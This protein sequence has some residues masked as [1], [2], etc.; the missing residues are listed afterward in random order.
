MLAAFVLAWMTIPVPLGSLVDAGGYRVHLYC[1][2]AGSPTVLIA[3]GAFSFDWAL[4]QPEVANFTRVCAYD[5]SGTAWSDSPPQPHPLCTDR[6]QELH[7]VLQKAGISPP[8]VLVG[9]SIGGLIARLYALAYL[10]EIAGMVIVNHAFLDVA[11]DVPPPP[12]VTSDSPPVLISSTPITFGLEDDKNFSRLPEHIR[13]LHAWALSRHPLRPANPTSRT[14]G[15]HKQESH[16]GSPGS[17][18]DHMPLG[19]ILNSGLPRAFAYPFHD[20]GF[21]MSAPALAGS[22]LVKRPRAPL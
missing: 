22:G 8:Y 2:G 11:P 19:S 14:N 10:H 13:N 16:H 7:R 15:S 12:P 18:M 5:P 17:P 4:I 20:C 21:M 3:G 1:T 9:F 6:V